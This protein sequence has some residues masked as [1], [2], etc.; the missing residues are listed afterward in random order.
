MFVDELQKS[1]SSSIDHFND[2]AVPVA[3][4]KLG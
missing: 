1:A 4:A 2:I 3:G